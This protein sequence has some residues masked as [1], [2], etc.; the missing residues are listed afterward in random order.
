MMKRGRCAYR[1]RFW[2]HEKGPRERAFRVLR[3][4]WIVHAIKKVDRFSLM[5]CAV[6]ELLFAYTMRT[7]QM[8]AAAVL[9]L[10]FLLVG[11]QR[12]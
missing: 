7:V 12:G 11:E 9:P 1:P 5:P 6:E 4:R 2:L 3:V 8:R 10:R